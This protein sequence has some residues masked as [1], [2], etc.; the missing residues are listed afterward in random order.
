MRSEEEIKDK[1]NDAMMA[2]LESGGGGF[3][4]G[5]AHALRWVMGETDD[6]PVEDE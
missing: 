6:D 1:M 4:S 2:E 3:E 5:V